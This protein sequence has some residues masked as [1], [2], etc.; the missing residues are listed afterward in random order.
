MKFVSYYKDMFLQRSQ[1]IS[2]GMLVV[3]G[4]GVPRGIVLF[5]PV[6]G[7]FM[8]RLCVL[9]QLD[10]SP[11]TGA[12]AHGTLLPPDLCGLLHCLLPGHHSFHAD[13]LCG[14]P[15]EL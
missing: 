7:L 5:H 11:C 8:G 13:L 14:F 3:G 4:G 1:V 2:Q 12:D 9:D 10:P 15:G 6:T